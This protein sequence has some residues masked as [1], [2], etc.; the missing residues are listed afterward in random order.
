MDTYQEKTLGLLLTQL[1][2]TRTHIG[3][4][5]LPVVNTAPVHTD[6]YQEKT[7]CLLSTQLLSTW[8]HIRRR[9]LAC[10]QHSSCPHIHI[11]REDTWPVVN[12]ILVNTDT[13]QEK[14]LGLLLTQLLS[15]YQEKTLGLLTQ[16]LSTWTHIGEDTL[17]VVN[18]APV[19]TDTYRRRHFACCQHS[20]CPHRHISGEDTWP[21]V[22]TAP[23]HTDT[24]RRR[25]FACCQHSSCP[26]RHISG[27]DTL[28]VVNTVPV[29]ISCYIS[30]SCSKW[31]I[32]WFCSWHT[33]GMVR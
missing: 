29:H 11:S 32:V 20:S 7:L 4:D 25:H 27:E 9:H 23:V 33:L 26:H 10:C 6:T 31:C 5:T 1:L 19:H 21:V 22:N 8:T 12:T 16:F 30:M 17:P 28:P 14:T 15:T 13:Y 2:S 24:Y 18:T 3:E